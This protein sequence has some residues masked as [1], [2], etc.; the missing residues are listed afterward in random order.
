MTI[1]R[2]L[3]PNKTW[4]HGT[5]IEPD[6]VVTAQPEQPGDDPALDAALEVLSESA[7][8]LRER[9]AA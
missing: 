7:T 4:I 9:A 5:G 1:A 6:V 2:W 3:T 8:G